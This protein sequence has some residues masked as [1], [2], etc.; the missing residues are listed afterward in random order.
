MTPE[1]DKAGAG[2]P[3]AAA[4]AGPDRSGRQRV[5]LLNL[6]LVTTAVVLQL[7]VGRHLGRPPTGVSAIP[8]VALALLFALAEM[9]VVHLKFRHDAH[10][11]SLSEIPLMLGLFFA[12]PGTVLLA[13]VIGG[14]A[15][16]A[17]HR[18]QSLIKLAFNLA[19]Y[20][21]S[22]LSAAIAFRLVLG[23]GDPLGPR[24]WVAG[25][26]AALAASVV[27]VAAIYLAVSL[28]DG[29]PAP[30]EFLRPFSF[31][32][33][34]ALVTSSIGLIAVEVLASHPLGE[35]LLVVPTVGLYIAN[36]AYVGERQKH[37]S[38]QFLYNSTRLFHQSPELDFA[39]D[40]MLAQ[41]REVL[42]ADVA[43]LAFYPAD[44]DRLLR[45][46]VGPGPTHEGMHEIDRNAMVQL[47][48]LF[49]QSAASHIFDNDASND[50]VRR[51]ACGVE[52]HNGIVVALQGETQVI[53]ALVVANHLSEVS[54]FQP[55][56]VRLL[57]TL[58]GQ[59]SVALENGR[60]EHSLAQLRVLERQLS[61]QATHD[62]LTGLANRALFSQRVSEA[63]TRPNRS[64]E[65]AVLFIDLDDFKTV[66]DSLGHSAG[67]ALLVAVAERVNSCLRDRDIAARLGGDEFAVLLDGVDG[68]RAAVA[69]AERI[70]ATLDL[71]VPVQGQNLTVHASVGVSLGSWG[72]DAATLM[73]NSDTAMYEAKA[74]G[75]GCWAL[76]SPDMH[77]AAL[78]RQELIQDLLGALD[79]DGFVVYFEPI[80]DLHADRIVAAEAL[81]RWAHPD[82]GLLSPESFIALAEETGHIGRITQAVLSK[83]CR[84][85]AGWP[86]DPQSGR[87]PAV[88]VNLSARD[89][90]SR[91]LIDIIF[92]T[93][94]STG[95]PPERLIL[96]ITESLMLSD[97]ARSV[98]ILR[99][100]AARGVRIAL[101]DFGTGYSSLSYLGQLPLHWMKIAKPFVDDLGTDPAHDALAHG[102]IEL[103]HVLQL[104]II[105]EG[106]ERPDQLATLQRFGCDTGQGYLY[107]HPMTSDQF[108]DWLNEH[109]AGG[110]NGPALSACR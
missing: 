56:D 80:I 108:L 35:L 58:A 96:E 77:D 26:T 106:I 13:Q 97:T 29:R 27:A 91:D 72:A 3:P 102:I 83:A 7:A 64:R 90:N 82:K 8:V 36:H 21:V 41:A 53:G 43:V 99:E 1:D 103:G 2:N 47:Q 17:V 40:A 30:R 51:L 55:A 10:T 100:L 59:V 98:E 52:V 18:R 105:A 63:L 57:E 88:S 69:A 25:S 87:A 6:A 49:D 16:L 79:D 33:F 81:V 65:L 68:R 15:V 23:A 20:A 32:A 50:I 62:A 46:R 31:A 70:L 75:K 24:G 48:S 85:A 93:L 73:R 11:F 107:S 92:S 74:R 54:G 5:W 37:Q 89:F 45:C 95:L 34:G 38:L 71:P 86:V 22:V 9:F 28:S 61:Y 94:N 19:N 104:G 60:L 76:F 4:T 84:L 39:V 109:H 12:A 101:D 44:G 67:D 42:R 14:G 110:R 78:R 66:N